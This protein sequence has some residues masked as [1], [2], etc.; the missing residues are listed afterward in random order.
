MSS[1]DTSRSLLRAVP[2]G[3]FA[4]SHISL[5]ASTLRRNTVL[6][7]CPIVWL[8]FVQVLVPDTQASSSERFRRHRTPAAPLWTCVG[9]HTHSYSLRQRSSLQDV[10]SSTTHSTEQSQP[11]HALTR[12]HQLQQP[13]GTIAASAGARSFAK[14][15]GNG[16]KSA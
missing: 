6:S 5:G 7:P 13:A 16:G 1:G 12:V 8:A 10:D 3:L 9:V 2:I 15:F 14:G 11:G 4:R